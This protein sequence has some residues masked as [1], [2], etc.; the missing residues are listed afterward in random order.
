[1]KKGPQ[2]VFSSILS[3]DS[4]QYYCLVQ[5][6]LRTKSELISVT[7]KYA[8]KT[9][10]VTV[11]PSG[12]IEE[13]SSVTLS[14]SSDANPAAT[15]T[16]F[17][18]LTDS[19]TRHISSRSMNQGPELI[20]SYIRSSDSGQYRCDATNKLGKKSV[21]YSIDVKYGPK[22][23]SVVSSASGEIMEGSSV[24]LSCSSDA[25]PAA[26]YTWFKVDTDGY[27]RHIFSRSMNQGPELIFSYIWSWNSG[28]YRCDAANK[29][30]KK[31]VTYSIDV[32]YGPKHTS[33]LSS[34][35]GEIEEGS[36]VTLSCSSDANPAAKYTWFKVDTDGSSRYMNHGP[37]LIFK[38][39]RSSDI[40]QYRC[41]AQNELRKESVTKSIDV[42]YAPKTP[43]VTVSPS[44]EIEE[45]SSVTLS[46]SSDA[47]PAATYT[48][49]KVNRDGSS[50][51]MNQGQ[52]LVLRQIPSSDSGQYRCDAQNKLG[53]KSFSISINLKYGPEHTSV[54][55]S[56]SG[57]IKEGSSVTLSCSSDANP[58][59]NYTWFRVNRD[60][61]STY[62]NHG[63]QLTFR[64]ILSSNSGQYRCDAQ[65]KLR[66]ESVTKSIDVKYAPKT[67]SVT[68]SPSGEI[69][70]G[71][72]VTLSC[73]SDARGVNW[74]WQAEGEG[75]GSEGGIQAVNE[76]V[77]YSSTCAGDADANRETE[78]TCMEAENSSTP[79]SR[80]EIRV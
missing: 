54:L 76:A 64:R 49:F 37:Q 51:Y 2:L 23:T 35:S 60:G 62:M 57:E 14:C 48:W 77:S 24:T 30:G 67:P 16:W 3:A 38:P 56:P 80:I 69:E 74:V 26:E 59:A 13:G 22:L 43:S 31:S 32:K 21:T 20:F 52:R 29:M 36:S 9:P 7:V 72:S 73:S 12:E 65:N 46:C 42:K 1:M 44:G 40:G 53:E 19:Y 28:Q 15:Y 11:R 4:G 78:T 58:A 45:G 66:K 71:S 34:P 75:P 68:V 61:S 63:P 79:T 55:S 5:T 17:K 8:P 41:D 6:E 47:N 18:V 10:S 39:I 70:E 27:Y 25:N 50:R 33:V